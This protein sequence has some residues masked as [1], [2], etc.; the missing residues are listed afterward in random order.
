MKINDI[1]VG[2]STKS[3]VVGAIKAFTKSQMYRDG[4]V[5]YRGAIKRDTWFISVPPSGARTHPLDTQLWMHNTINNVSEEHNGYKVRNGIFC[6]EDK[7]TAVHYGTNLYV[8]IPTEKAVF[9]RHEYIG[10]LTGYLESD[11]MEHNFIEYCY[12]QE[13]DIESLN[14]TEKYN[15]FREFIS[16][17]VAPTYID[18]LEKLY[19]NDHWSSSENEVMV[20]GDFYI[21]PVEYATKMINEIDPEGDYI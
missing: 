13:I 10:D 17:F 8:I 18:L 6:T 21:V 7:D 1:D 2:M 15:T 16:Y 9:F 11:A 4:I 5:L 14:D 12:D 3:D 19:M 20:F